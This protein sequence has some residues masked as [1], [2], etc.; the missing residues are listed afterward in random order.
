MKRD[1]YKIR[2]GLIALMCV[3]D[4]IRHLN[5]Q[6]YLYNN[7][8]RDYEECNIVSTY[9]IFYIDR[10]RI[11]IG[12][13][14]LEFFVKKRMIDEYKGQLYIWNAQGWYSSDTYELKIAR[15][16]NHLEFENTKYITN[17][18]II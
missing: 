6:Q 3:G 16:I 10:N 2:E 17:N 1:D 14:R 12:T 7:S 18:L 5:I 13:H 4:T 11:G 9:K 15:L 8:I